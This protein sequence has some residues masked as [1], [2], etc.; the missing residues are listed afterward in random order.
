MKAMDF[1]V[2]EILVVYVL[3]YGVSLDLAVVLRMRTGWEF[4]EA[5]S[6][7]MFFALSVLLVVM[8]ILKG[9]RRGFPKGRAVLTL[10]TVLFAASLACDAVLLPPYPSFRTIAAAVLLG[11]SWLF[12]AFSFR[13]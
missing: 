12:W 5:F 4:G 7:A 1:K 10:A 11:L 2:R 6:L 3:C 9:Q 13:P 8:D